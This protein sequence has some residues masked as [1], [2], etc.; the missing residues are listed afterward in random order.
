MEY[1]KTLRDFTVGKISV[2][3]ADVFE[4]NNGQTIRDTKTIYKRKN[5]QFFY[6]FNELYHYIKGGP[7]GRKQVSMLHLAEKKSLSP[8]PF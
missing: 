8:F 3:E 6:N 1:L 4:F 2:E 7:R 5:Q